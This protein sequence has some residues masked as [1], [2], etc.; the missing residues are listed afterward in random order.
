MWLYFSRECPAAGTS[1][2]AEET[3][4]IY[5]IAHLGH[6]PSPHTVRK[7]AVCESV[8]WLLCCGTLLYQ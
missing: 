2:P 3:D 1:S 7:R 5:F 6:S 4:R 8:L